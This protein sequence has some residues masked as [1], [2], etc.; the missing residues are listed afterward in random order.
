MTYILD[1]ADPAQATALIQY[2]DSLD[3]VT[4]RQSS[5]D[6]DRPDQADRMTAINR[7]K[8]LLARR[9]KQDAD[10]AEVTEAVNEIRQEGGYH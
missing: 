2:L 10:Q 3:Y 6:A 7:T 4:L 5:A 8:A 9:P 1:I